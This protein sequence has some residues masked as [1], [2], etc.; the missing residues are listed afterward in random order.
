MGSLSAR[1]FGLFL[2]FSLAMALVPYG[3]YSGT[4]GW[5]VAGAG[6]LLLFV[7]L[8]GLLVPRA[9]KAAGP[10][11]RKLANALL[12]FFGAFLV[13]EFLIMGFMMWI[14]GNRTFPDNSAYQTLGLILFL[15]LL[16]VG[17][18]GAL[19]TFI[20]LF[21]VYNTGAIERRHAHAD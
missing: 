7:V 13:L 2:V 18:M 19:A 11:R 16:G 12:Q 10:E 17:I 4:W 3:L 5:S 1:L 21:Y 6:L 20:Y 9:L 8:G 15:G 14:Y